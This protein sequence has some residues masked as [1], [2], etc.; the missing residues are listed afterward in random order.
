MTPDAQ[1]HRPDPDYLRSL[2]ERSGLSQREAAR[3]LGLTDRAMRYYLSATDE[4][5][6]PY[7][8]QFALEALAANNTVIISFEALNT[9]LLMELEAMTPAMPPI[10]AP[11]HKGICHQD[12]CAHCS[13]IARARALIETTKGERR[14]Y[15]V[16]GA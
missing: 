7:V 3:R 12:E 4:V 13:R 5:R 10:D 1:H 9:K 15:R 16:V 6:A 11:C 8:V 14:T 2:V